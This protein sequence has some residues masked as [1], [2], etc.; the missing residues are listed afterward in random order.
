MDVYETP[1]ASFFQIFLTSSLI[2]S[3]VWIITKIFFAK[4]IAVV[5]PTMVL[6]VVVPGRKKRK[7]AQ[8]EHRWKEALATHPHYCNVC[9]NMMDEGLNCEICGFCVHSGCFP[10]MNKLVECKRIALKENGAKIK[11]R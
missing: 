7:Q 9:E 10:K 8:D 3:F 6:N 5:G 2:L 1:P 4:N 11:H